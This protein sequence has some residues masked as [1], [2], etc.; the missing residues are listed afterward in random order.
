MKLEEALMKYVLKLTTIQCFV[1]VF[2][3]VVV[4]LCSLYHEKV[5]YMYSVLYMYQAVIA[6]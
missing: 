6:N 3:I 5:L 2:A 4:I 1:I